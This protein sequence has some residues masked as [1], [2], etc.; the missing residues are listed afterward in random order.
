[1]IKTKNHS[2]AD[3]SDLHDFM[4]MSRDIDKVFIITFPGMRQNAL[5]ISSVKVTTEPKLANNDLKE[6]N[7]LTFCH[8]KWSE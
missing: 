6:R 4:S 5:C 1:M 2:S 3:S 8:I 7:R